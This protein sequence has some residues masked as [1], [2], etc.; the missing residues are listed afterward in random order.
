MRQSLNDLAAAAAGAA[1]SSGGGE[2][3][4]RAALDVVMREL[5]GQNWRVRGVGGGLV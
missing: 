3:A 4:P 5:L 1:G 2:D